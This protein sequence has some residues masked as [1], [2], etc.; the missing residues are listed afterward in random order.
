MALT[1]PKV[2]DRVILRPPKWDPEM[3]ITRHGTVEE[4][5][6]GRPS[7]GGLGEKRYAVRWDEGDQ[8]RDF[9]ATCLEHE[10]IEIPTFQVVE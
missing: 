8:G 1:N 5:Y 10:P 4:V 7:C 2:G 9:L 6:Y 3:E